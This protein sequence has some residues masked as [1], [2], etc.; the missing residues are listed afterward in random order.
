M[1]I[2]EAIAQL[3]NRGDLS[4]AE[5]AAVMSQIMSG[6]ATDAQIAG[7][8]VGLKVK[9]ETVEEIAGAADVMRQ[10]ATR[11]ETSHPVLVDTCGTGGDRS[12][13]FNIS[14]T[15]AFVVAGAGVPVAKH[16][17]RSITSK[18]GSADLLAGL[19]VKIDLPP[20]RVTRCLE[21]IGIGFL[22]APMLHT[23]MRYAIDVRRQLAPT[24]T[25]FNM[26]G[27]LTNPAGAKRQVVGVYRRE[28]VPMIAEVLR[29]LGSERAFVV[30]GSDGLDEITTTGE[31]TVAQLCDGRVTIGAVRPEDVGLE[32]ARQADL[33]GG[34]VMTNVGIT[35]AVLD[36]RQG[37]QRDIV[38][39][40]AAAALVAAGKATDLRGGVRLAAQSIDSGAARE[41][42]ARLVAMTNA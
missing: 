12:G 29:L 15:A 35:R 26:L 41:R 33:R 23:A 11:I 13:T 10:K 5:T 14:T 36:G 42:L 1:T 40:N 2:S 18:C 22:F 38:L 7:F 17:N 28:M 3:A 6:E 4:R 24:P 9:G 16:G 21:E 20:A 19:G 27:P 8:L 39:L 37:P 30:H 25:V 32:R 34:D 31:T